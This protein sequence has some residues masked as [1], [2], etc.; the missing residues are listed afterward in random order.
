MAR[1]N[2]QEIVIQLFWH[3]PGSGGPDKLDET[4]L[5]AQGGP[6]TTQEGMSVWIQTKVAEHRDKGPEGWIFLVCD[7]TS[8]YFVKTPAE[9]STPHADP[10]L[11]P[12]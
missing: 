2:R 4:Q 3:K 1:K 6:F 12:R 9:P 7:S 8:E 10:S 5:I 11:S